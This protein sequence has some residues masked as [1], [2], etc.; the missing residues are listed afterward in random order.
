[1]PR[2]VQNRRTALWGGC[3]AIVIGSLL[4]HDA[5]EG[6]GVGRPW[7]LKVLPGA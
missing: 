7:I 1:M 2:L 6:R 3:V 5:Y 4:L